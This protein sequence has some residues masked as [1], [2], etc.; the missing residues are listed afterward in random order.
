MKEANEL[1]ANCLS[2]LDLEKKNKRG[3]SIHFSTRLSVTRK[4]RK[5]SKWI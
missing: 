1:G 5:V 3:E 2:Q 4:I